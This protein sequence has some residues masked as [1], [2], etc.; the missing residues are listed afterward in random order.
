[1]NEARISDEFRQKMLIVELRRVAGARALHNSNANAKAVSCVTMALDDEFLRLRARCEELEAELG[2]M[3]AGFD[4]LPEHQAMMPMEMVTLRN[5]LAAM[6][7]ERDEAREQI[8][9]IQEAHKF[10]TP[11]DPTGVRNGLRFKAIEAER[12]AL[13]AQ[14]AERDGQVAALHEA[15]ARF[16]WDDH[17]TLIA[18]PMRSYVTGLLRDTAAASAAFLA[19]RDSRVRAEGFAAGAK[20]QHARAE[21]RERMRK[22]AQTKR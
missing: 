15:L 14:L 6:Q 20:A 5:Q 2:A 18:W 8:E 19:E 22:L 7:R 10:S 3:R 11:S 13:A 16:Q 12:E 21:W 4:V 9:I 17:D 1:M